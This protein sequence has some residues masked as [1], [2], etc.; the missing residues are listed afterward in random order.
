MPRTPRWKSWVAAVLLPL[1]SW[2]EHR[3]RTRCPR[4]KAKLF[5]AL[6]AVQAAYDR[7]PI[8]QQLAPD[9]E[10]G[11]ETLL[12]RWQATLCSTVHTLERPLGNPR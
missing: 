3:S 5:Q 12:E 8:T 9:V 6:E 2:Q 1:M 11:C 7:H 4:R 10:G